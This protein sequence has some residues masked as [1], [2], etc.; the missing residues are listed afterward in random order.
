M[1]SITDYYSGKSVFITGGTGFVGKVLIEKLLFTCQDLEKIY[2]LIREKE[3]VSP[4]RRFEQLINQSVFARIHNEMPDAFNKLVPVAGNIS[5]INLGIQPNIE[6]GFIDKISV[7]FHAAASVNFDEK[8]ELSMTS[9]FEGTRR[10]LQLSKRM[11]NLKKFIHVS[12]AYCHTNQSVL[13]EVVYPLPFALNTVDQDVSDRIYPTDVRF[14][15]FKNTRP[16]SYTV[17]KAMS[18]TLVAEN[19]AVPTVI[20]RPSI[21]SASMFEPMPGW[22]ENWNGATSIIATVATGLNHVVQ[23]DTRPIFLILTKHDWALRVLTLLLQKI[24][25][26]ITDFWRLSKGKKP[27]LVKLQSKL[28]K[29]RDVHKFFSSRSFPMRNE[30][31]MKLYYSMNQKDRTAFPFDPNQIQWNKYILQYCKGIKKYLLRR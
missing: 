14:H 9:N 25:A 29:N 7:I 12:T 16:N 22:I 19:S 6:S 18:E 5:E 28:I 24:P 3:D 2:I 1:K 11:N 23:D 17:A 13:E 26:Y 27:R 21:V 20:I 10:V 31:Q 4:Y 30:N 15:A 8:L